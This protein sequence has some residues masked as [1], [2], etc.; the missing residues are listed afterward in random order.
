MMIWK[1]FLTTSLS[2][3][4]LSSWGA[5]M[6]GDYADWSGASIKFGKIQG[7][8]QVDVATLLPAAIILGLIGGFLGAGFVYINFKVNGW[9]KKIITSNR[10][11][12]I[13][14]VIFAFVTASVFFWVPA[15]F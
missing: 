7:D 1:V 12:V 9:R 13:E 11:K 6:A 3:F 2:V 10:R 15:M 4:I 8:S 5:I 14:A